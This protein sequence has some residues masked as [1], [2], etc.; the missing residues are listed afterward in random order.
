L[1]HCY[2]P[3][4]CHE[5]LVQDYTGVAGGSFVVPDHEDLPYLELRLSA[6]DA[7]G[8][9][10]TAS[11][12]LAPAT[13]ALALR[14]NPAGLRITLDSQDYAT[15]IDKTVVAGSEHTL[16]TPEVQSHRSF[17]GWSDGSAERIRPVAIDTT[18]VTYTATYVNQTPVAKATATPANG[19][20]PLTVMFSGVQSSDPEGDPLNYHWDFG[21]GTT[22]TSPNP[23]YTY[24]TPG[25]RQAR[26]TVTDMLGASHSVTVTVNVNGGAGP[27]NVWLPLAVR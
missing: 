21:D 19:Q 22:S 9:S 5:H 13:T 2:S 24:T 4:N 8:L 1:H 11:V 3:T 14:S 12:L 20:A 15:P 10:D 7:G 16:I 18:P 26:L 17:A 27:R 6:T 23:M 25:G